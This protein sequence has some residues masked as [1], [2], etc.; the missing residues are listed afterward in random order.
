MVQCYIL[1][2][3]TSLAQAK[4]IIDRKEL[5]MEELKKKLHSSERKV[6]MLQ[7]QV[8]QLLRRVYGRRSE[9]LDPNQLMLEPLILEAINEPA[10][11]PEPIAPLLAK[12]E[13]KAP[14]KTKRKHPG[15][16]PIPEHLERVEIVLDVP[17]EQ[18]TCP[19]TGKPLK[20]IGWEVSEKLEY[21]PG[22]LIVNVYKRPKYGA[23]ESDVE[24]PGVVIAPMP[25]HPIDRCKA[26]VGL[27]SYI[28]VSKF[29]DHLP[30]YRQNGIFE[31]EGVDIP[32]GTQTSWILQ[33]Y[34]AIRPLGDELKKAVLESDVL[35]T[36]DSI[37]PLQVKGNGKVHKARLWAYV[38]GGTDSPLIVYDFS[39]DRSKKRPL[40]FLED[41]RGFVHA[42]AYSGYDELFRRKWVTEVGCWVHA[43]RKFDEAV[44]S[45]AIEATEV[46]A[47]IAQLYMVEAECA[48][49]TP[50]ERRLVREERS[51]P[52]LDG[53]FERL[54]ELKP[55][56]LPSEPFRKA[57]DYALNQRE[58]LY[59]YLKDGRLKP[60]NN[61][62]ENAIRPLALGRKNWL[63]AG[64]ERGARAT[65]LF[66]GLVQSCKACQV[67]PW[68]YFDDMLKRIMSYPVH[69]LRE[70]LPDNWR[71]LPK[72]EHG[73]IIPDI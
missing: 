1:C 32:R 28:I 46:M 50:Q 54:E 34:E 55:N 25:D 26:D 20:Q 43:R 42:D 14:P 62:A 58:A 71:P 37:I 70:L 53:I 65:A 31:R 39:R 9:R 16:I 52:I 73:L 30:L 13:R 68:E 3:L 48:D 4:E 6:S 27:L 24:G 56:T 67:N 12:P 64:S 23:S 2:M 11:S 7:H 66:L 5:Q 19:D 8:E 18:K 41:Y 47:R 10:P 44:S 69:R 72:D 29:A 17:E 40:D 15:R 59:R 33:T 51:R 45:R 49:M 22:K 60:D 35:F 38:R 57:I 63:F 61:I 36:D 21:R